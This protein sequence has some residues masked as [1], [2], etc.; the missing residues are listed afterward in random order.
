[1][2]LKELNREPRTEKELKREWYPL[3]GKISIR[4]WNGLDQSAG[5]KIQSNPNGF[6]LDWILKSPVQRILDWTGSE[7]Y[8]FLLSCWKANRYRHKTYNVLGDFWQQSLPK[9]SWRKLIC[10]YILIHLTL[11]KNCT[12]R[13]K[14]IGLDLIG[15]WSTKPDWTGSGSPAN[16]LGLY[17]ILSKESVSYLLWFQ[18]LGTNWVTW[19]K[20]TDIKTRDTKV[21][22]TS[23]HIKFEKF[24][25]I[26][27]RTAAVSQA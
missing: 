6:G 26:P 11:Q 5:L 27:V 8:H 22:C 7:I 14:R 20:V 16:G 2:I 3:N 25:S 17:W 4:V 21:V 19:A 24:E 23:S 15:F 12:V 18:Y 9:Y 10:M 13:I 1:M